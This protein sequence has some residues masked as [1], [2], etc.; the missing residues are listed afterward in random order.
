M[1][2][3][4]KGTGTKTAFQPSEGGGGGEGIERAAQ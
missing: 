4:P 2:K 1:A 3:F